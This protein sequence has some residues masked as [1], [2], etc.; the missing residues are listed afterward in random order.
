MKLTLI[1]LYVLPLTLIFGYSMVQLH[2]AINY[3]RFHKRKSPAASPPQLAES[4]LPVVTV[5]LPIFNELYV[6]ERLIDNIAQFDYPVG[7]LEIQVLDDST[8]E[9]VEI[10]R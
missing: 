6:V 7:K 5:Q 2:L 4:E 1:I 10:S 3:L 9:T 8:D